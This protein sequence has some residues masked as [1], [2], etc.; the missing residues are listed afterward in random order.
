MNNQKSDCSKYREV[1]RKLLEK[2][3]EKLNKNE[4][5]QEKKTCNKC[6]RKK[7]KKIVE[8]KCSDILEKIK[9]PLSL[10]EKYTN[11]QHVVCFSEKTQNTNSRKQNG[12]IY[13]T[14]ESKPCKGTL[15]IL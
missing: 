4:N 9:P 15:Q 6:P 2:K 14:A 10:R 7:I 1:K 13:T 12:I 11:P 3:K 8:P 5:C